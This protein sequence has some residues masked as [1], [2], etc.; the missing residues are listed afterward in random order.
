MERW[1]GTFFPS[2]PRCTSLAAQTFHKHCPR[3]ILDGMA[4][5]RLAAR[6]HLRSAKRWEPGAHSF[7][8]GPL[9]GLH[10]HSVRL[11]PAP[12]FNALV[13]HVCGPGPVQGGLLAACIGVANNRSR[14]PHPDRGY[15]FRKAQG[16]GYDHVARVVAFRAPPAC[17]NAGRPPLPGSKSRRIDFLGELWHRPQPPRR[18]AQSPGSAFP[19]PRFGLA[20]HGRGHGSGSYRKPAQIWLD[21]GLGRHG[22]W[23]SARGGELVLSASCRPQS[24]S[25]APASDLS[26]L[27][28]LEMVCLRARL[29][30]RTAERNLYTATIRLPRGRLVCLNRRSCDR[31]VAR[32]R[33]RSD[34]H[35]Y[36]PLFG[37]LAASGAAYAALWFESRAEPPSLT[38]V[39]F[40]FPLPPNAIL[41]RI[42]C[43]RQ[44][45]CIFTVSQFF[46][47]RLVS[48]PPPRNLFVLNPRRHLNPRALSIFQAPSPGC[49]PS[50]NSSRPS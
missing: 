15:R 1:R 23:Q 19:H 42:V 20:R 50:R 9:P 46:S 14:P 3:A 6:F 28:G 31:G 32:E 17:R 36:Y 48:S 7:A 11:I 4:A 40:H 5:Q 21:R 47:W 37:R 2:H 12:L 38:L 24:I 13:R 39:A 16:C 29:L 43:L 44:L 27:A 30:E 25:Y 33:G 8:R 49:L 41:L 10:F 26:N 35:P 18:M 34:P 22:F 45:L